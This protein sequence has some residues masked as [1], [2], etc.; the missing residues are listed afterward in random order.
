MRYI[1]IAYLLIGLLFGL[2][3]INRAKK[4]PIWKRVAVAGLFI[5]FWAPYLFYPFI[6]G[7]IAGARAKNKKSP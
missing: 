1:I 6:E 3:I 2:R 5:V 7:L 4:D